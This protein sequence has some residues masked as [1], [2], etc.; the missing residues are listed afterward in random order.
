[1][2][3][4]VK[5]QVFRIDRAICEMMDA[6]IDVGL[7]TSYTEIFR[8]GVRELY[9]KYKAFLEPNPTLSEDRLVRV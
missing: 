7:F 8:A 6:L 3:E 9:D 5:R 2:N 4:D 1:M